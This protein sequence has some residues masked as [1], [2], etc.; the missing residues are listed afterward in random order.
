MEWKCN[1]LNCNC[2][3]DKETG[4]ITHWHFSKELWDKLAEIPKEVSEQLFFSSTTIWTKEFLE[5]KE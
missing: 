3:P 1:K 4:L 2:K 5:E